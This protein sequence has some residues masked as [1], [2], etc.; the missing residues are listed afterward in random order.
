MPKRKY[1]SF[2]HYTHVESLKAIFKSGEIRFT[3]TI[4]QN[5]IQ[6]RKLLESANRL[7][8]YSSSFC[9]LKE[10]IPLWFIY[11]KDKDENYGVMINFVLKKG[12]NYSDFFLDKRVICDNIH[13]Y[14]QKDFKRYCVEP[15]SMPIQEIGFI[16]SNYWKYEKEQRFLLQKACPDEN[17]HD[18]CKIN[19]DAISKIDIYISPNVVNIDQKSLRKELEGKI[20]AKIEYH[21][22]RSKIRKIYDNN[23]ETK[24]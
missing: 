19:L 7:D 15:N 4:N 17:G 3:K 5:D 21:V 22:H 24:K 6:E 1:L 11:S 10:Y 18:Y 8:L 13:Y 23:P 20:L 2:S 14:S 12:K 16:K 9:L